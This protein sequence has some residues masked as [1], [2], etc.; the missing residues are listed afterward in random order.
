MLH[1]IDKNKLKERKECQ[2]KWQG[3]KENNI[4]FKYKDKTK[5]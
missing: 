2:L 1:L 3:I 5:P 4:C